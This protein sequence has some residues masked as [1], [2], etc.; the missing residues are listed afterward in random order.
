MPEAD[1]RDRF[2]G[3]IEIV[4][5][6]LLAL[7]AILSAW[8]AFQATKWGGEEAAS[9]RRAA[10]AG[11]AASQQTTIAN[12]QHDIDV[13]TFLQWLE[14]ARDDIVAGGLDPALVPYVPDPRTLSGFIALR[15]RD[16]FRPA[17]D[18]W[19]A[20]RPIENPDAPNTPFELPEYELAA[21]ARIEA[22][23]EEA[24]AHNEDARKANERG[25]NYVRLTVLFAIALVFAGIGAKTERLTSSLFL[26][27]LAFIA[28]VVAIAALVSYPVDI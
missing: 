7:A 6:V 11:V 27:G 4:A 21:D 1:A 5:T 23:Q 2:A 18:A 15:F 22:L 3:R 19:F 26:I 13:T 16:E 17:F 28:L 10:A 9:S 8:S 20:A 25:D 12:T 24:N 14:A